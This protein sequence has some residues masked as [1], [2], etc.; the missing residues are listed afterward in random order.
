[1][2]GKYHNTRG[3]ARQVHFLPDWKKDPVM[4]EAMKTTHVWRN[5]TGKTF[6]CQG[7]KWGEPATLRAADLSE[8]SEEWR[9]AR[10]EELGRMADL[11]A[12]ELVEPTQEMNIL[13]SRWV[14]TLK[15]N[16][17]G[18]LER[19]KARLVAQG[20]GQKEGI[21]FDQTFASTAGMTTVR[22]FL[23]MVGLFNL[24]CH[25]LDVTTAF[26]YGEVDKDIYMRQPP[27]HTDGT[28]RVCKLIR[29]IYGL[30]QSPRIWQQKLEASLVKLGFQVSRLDPS[31]YLL[32][33]NGES[34]LLLDFVDDILI[35]SSNLELIAEIKAGLCQEYT[36]KDLGEATRYIGIHIVRR[37]GQIWLHQA[38]YCLQM[39]ERF[40]VTSGPY[41]STPLSS[42][43]EL[44]RPWED[45]RTD[46]EPPAHRVD[47]YEPPL[48]PEQQNL[49]Q[50]IVGSLH[51]AAHTTRIDIAHAVGQLAKVTSRPRQRHLVAARRC[52][53]YLVGTAEH[54]LHYSTNDGKRLEVYV[55]ANYAQDAG[56]KSTTGLVLTIG[57]GAVYWTSRKQDRQTTSTCD[58]ESQAVM[59]AVQ[60]VEHMRDLLAELGC[61]QYGATPL[62]ND[63]SATIKL[64]IDPRAHKR[65]VQL[66]RAMSYVREHTR[67]G[68]ITP[69][70]IPTADMPADFL[71]KRLP[72]DDFIRCRV[73]SGLQPLPD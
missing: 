57:G 55:D 40:G 52:V 63:N 9:D 61:V 59:T 14:F 18:T 72:P 37:P 23:A 33:R 22:T 56:R 32:E 64:C 26:L 58:A 19:Y 41:P 10:L 54:G 13:G 43:F 49:Y 1:M 38:T 35:A 50:Q 70:H 11:R 17:D 60:Y 12:W 24:H 15:R 20:F 65:S 29:S 8:D 31:L 36:M 44:F 48:S 25:Q 67:R 71:T 66:T 73:R 47:E 51:F 4:R 21:D 16:P 5:R 68:R 30:K 45:L 6:R 28:P 39:A 3:G 46:D 27:G 34:T 69:Q 2:M 42:D 7:P 53:A 62:Y